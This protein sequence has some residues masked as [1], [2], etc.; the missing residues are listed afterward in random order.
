M[1]KRRK[2]AHHP[3]RRLDTNLHVQICGYGNGVV[4]FFGGG[5]HYTIVLVPLLAYIIYQFQILSYFSKAI[6]THR[7]H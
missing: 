1:K 5:G 7:K 6:E 2:G 4:F 3:P